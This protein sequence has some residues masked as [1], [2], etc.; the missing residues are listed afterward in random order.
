MTG[1]S[2]SMICLADRCPRMC[3]SIIDKRSSSA[4]PKYSCSRVLMLGKIFCSKMAYRKKISNCYLDLFLVHTEDS[5]LHSTRMARRSDWAEG[6]DSA[7]A[8]SRPIRSL[9]RLA[10]SSYSRVISSRRLRFP[11]LCSSS[12]AAPMKVALGAAVVARGSGV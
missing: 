12:S 4:S 6:S 1:S 11:R 10:S 3:C 9:L 2:S 7:S 8:L 5:P